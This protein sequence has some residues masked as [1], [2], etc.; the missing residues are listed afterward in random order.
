MPP[1]EEELFGNQMAKLE[2][3]GMV[4]ANLQ[5]LCTSDVLAV[6]KLLHDQQQGT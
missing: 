2:A 1:D 3:A 4:F 5:A 6:D